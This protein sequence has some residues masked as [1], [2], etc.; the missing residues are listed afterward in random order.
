MNYKKISSIL[1]AKQEPVKVELN[2]LNE[3]KAFQSEIDAASAKASDLLK[4]AAIALLA[5]GKISAQALTQARK[6]SAIAKELGVDEGQFKGWERQYS[7]SR[8]TFDA[9]TK[10]IDRIINN[11]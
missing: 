5:A 4:S 6:A 2:A 7:M 11:I 9:S 8:D 1:F 10:T 3:L